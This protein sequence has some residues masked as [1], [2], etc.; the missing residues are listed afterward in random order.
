MFWI[1][2]E[3][4]LSNWKVGASIFW[5]PKV[6]T[7]ITGPPRPIFGRQAAAFY[8]AK[9]RQGLGLGGPCQPWRPCSKVTK[10][11]WL[12]SAA[13]TIIQAN[14]RLIKDPL[15]SKSDE[16]LG[17]AQLQ[18]G[19]CGGSERTQYL[20]SCM[21]SWQSMKCSTEIQILPEVLE[22]P[23]LLDLKNFNLPHCTE[24]HSCMFCL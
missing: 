19:G 13:S 6:S 3:Q 2:A 7:Q 1:V 12:V 15:E 8:S 5:Y 9:S 24:T 23:T 22:S 4:C 17:S 10:I 21:F 18:T 11:K 14:E 16:L 20:H